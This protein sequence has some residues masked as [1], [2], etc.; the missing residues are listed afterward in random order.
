MSKLPLLRATVLIQPLHGSDG[1][2][3]G[4]RWK[5]ESEVAQSCLTLCDA[6]DC[7]LLGYSVYEI[8]QARILECVAMLSF[9][10][11]SQPRGQTRV[12]YIS[13]VSRWVLYH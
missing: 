2:I 6:I 7:S 13:Y 5:S 9:R 12:S 1:D 4:W 3:E 10:G 11:S 8:L